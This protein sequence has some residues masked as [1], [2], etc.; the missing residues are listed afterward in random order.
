MNKVT[1]ESIDLSG[2]LADSNARSYSS[3]GYDDEAGSLSPG[4]GVSPF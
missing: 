3:R 1:M 2:L 4:I